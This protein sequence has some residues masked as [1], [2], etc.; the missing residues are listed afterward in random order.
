MPALSTV[1][2]SGYSAYSERKQVIDDKKNF[3]SDLDDQIGRW[4]LRDAG[5]GYNIVSVFGSQSSGKSTLLNRLFGTNFEVMENARRQQT[6][7][8][9]WM[10]RAKS[11]NIL[12]MDVEG[13]DGRERG[14][15]SDL[16]RKFALF[17]VASSEILIINM[18]EHQVGLH[19]GANMTLL[20]TVFDVNLGLFGKKVKEGTSNRTLLLFVI[21]D[22]VSQTPLSI[23]QSTVAADLARIW[24][25]LH[26]PPELKNCRLSDF[27]DL[28]FVSLPHKI[29][30]P[31][32]FEASIALLR[33]RFVNKDQEGYL[34]KS[35]Y[36]KR[37][38]ADG[39]SFYMN[40]I[41][42]RVLNNKDLDLPAQHELLSQFRC[43]QISSAAL[44][45]FYENAKS[46]KRPLETGH[47]V[48][49]IGSMMK[50]WQSDVLTKYDR[51]ASR[52]H[53]QVY[54]RKRGELVDAMNAT[55]STLFLGQLKNL[56]RA[57]L[58]EFEQQVVKGMKG[59]K[60]NFGDV[61]SNTRKRC[62]EKFTNIAEEASIKG[63][64]WNWRIE[65]E[66][67]MG[68]V[69]HIADQFRKDET[70][71]MLN[72]IERKFKVNISDPVESVLNKPAA[73][74]WDNTLIAFKNALLQGEETYMAK[75]T[76]CNCTDDENSAS[77]AELRRRLWQALRVKIDEQVAEALVLN[78]L[79]CY[80]E[81]RFRYDESGV[82]KV[83]KPSDDIN[84]VFELAKAETLQMVPLYSKIAPSDARNAFKLPE[85][86]ANTADQCEITT[87]LL[88]L[89]DAKVEDLRT[90]FRRD[91]DAHYMEV[92]RS[93]KTEI[94]QIPRWV[95]ALLILVGWN[96]AMA[97]LFNPIYL[98]L[99]LAMFAILNFVIQ[100]KLSRPLYHA[101]STA[102]AG[103]LEQNHGMLRMQLVRSLA[104]R[105]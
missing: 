98:L 46:Q 93:I 23:L 17:S 87:S 49:G 96:E 65:L 99:L 94:A 11:S 80:F 100:F 2:T 3:T 68:E 103:I 42:K 14:G 58:I 72:V 62:Q 43:D 73:D 29:L 55:F 86:N 30:Q 61:V 36:H 64:D 90:K 88:V 16:D 89:S 20:R 74:M 82:P 44:S 97:I 85:N 27:F 15:E 78:R 47:V 51:E 69:Q 33:T 12:V 104:K 34:F 4:G 83:W 1:T 57:C 54:M 19:K 24:R 28:A 9:I 81:E 67:L 79:K 66:S 31:E 22:H 84:G 8:G 6:T 76:S 70:K 7:K 52:Y 25:S 92:K 75:A 71:R 48:E 60:Y 35:A 102:F 59:A 101:A 37:V 63:M 45:E 53:Q 95:Y 91:A 26:K 50:S 40:N 5:T 10:S 39:L 21:R 41:W 32:K 18:W 56:H 38:P 105:D 77:L 13:T